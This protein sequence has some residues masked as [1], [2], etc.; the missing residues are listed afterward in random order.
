MTDQVVTEDVVLFEE[1]PSGNGKKI[2]VAT[3]NAEKA[4]NSLSLEMVRLL[5]PQLNVWADDDSIACVILQGAGDKA[6]C[7]GGDIVQLY[8]GMKDATDYPETFF[9]EEYRL[10][11]AIHT[12]SKPLVV[13]GNGVV[14][15]GGLGLMSGGSH[16]VVTE[17]TR[18][19]M[20][21]VTIGLYPDVG[22]T[23]FL[24]HAPGN[25]GLFLGLTGASINAAD[26]IYVGLA[27]SFVTHDQRQAVIDALAAIAWS[28]NA[29][30]QVAEVIAE[31]E[32][33]SSGAKPA[34]QVEAHYDYI[35]QSTD[36]SSV[37]EVV[38]AITG[39]DGDDKWLVNAAK[40]M[41]QG[42]PATI[43]LVWEQL[44]RGK[45][46]SLNDIF[47]MEMIISAN[48]ARIGNFQEGVRALLI[49]KDRDPK[50]KPAT[51]AEVTP[52]FVEQHFTPPWD[53]EHPLAEL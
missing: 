8:H 21:E 43:Y 45:G 15:G 17:T 34:G 51:V 9:A 1:I 16:R 18:M 11:Y 48:C 49:E 24:N 13:W 23:W 39:Y 37:P 27:D 40:G 6:F 52:E 42:C 38:A 47:K 10:D 32:S 5:H 50:F 36:Y 35:Q 14:M 28:E 12:Y 20:P 53:G 2:A 22:G 44:Q 33:K 19:A 3:L 25:T 29:H 26:A 46:M 7:A 31:F 4:L 41:A 30:D